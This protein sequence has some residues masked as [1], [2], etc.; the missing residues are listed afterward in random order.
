MMPTTCPGSAF[1]ATRASLGDHGVPRNARHPRLSDGPR[2]WRI[3]GVPRWL[4]RV[5]FSCGHGY[6]CTSACWEGAQSSA[7]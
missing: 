4:G 6:P 5:L 1:V 7:S 2:R 3:G